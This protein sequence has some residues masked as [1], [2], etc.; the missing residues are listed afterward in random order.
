MTSEI[1]QWL[2]S[3]P[4]HTGTHLEKST[5]LLLGVLPPL[6]CFLT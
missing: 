2:G 6:N 5:I 3:K 1:V 4:Y